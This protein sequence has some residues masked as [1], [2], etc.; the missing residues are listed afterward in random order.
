MVTPVLSRLTIIIISTIIQEI[1]DA[2]PLKAA[3]KFF[4]SYG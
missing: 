2:V 1:F 3:E 4:P